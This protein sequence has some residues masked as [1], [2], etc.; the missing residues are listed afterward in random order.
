MPTNHLMAQVNGS[1]NGVMVRATAGVTMY[2]GAGAGSEQT[3]SAVIAD[4]VDVAR[5]DGTHAA[6]QVPHLGFM[7]TPWTKQLAVLPRAAIITRH[8]LRV[9][10]HSAE[11]IRAVGAWL[12]AQR[13]PVVQMALAAEK[14]RPLGSGP[15][16]LVLTESVAQS[17]VDWAVH[18]L[19]AHPAV[20]GGGDAAGRAAGRLR[21]AQRS[22]FMV[23]I[24]S[25]A[26]PA[27]AGSYSF[28]CKRRINYG[29]AP[30]RTSAAISAAA[31]VPSARR[32]C[33]TPARSVSMRF[34]L[35]FQRPSQRSTASSMPTMARSSLSM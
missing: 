21:N 3:A 26:Y 24:G 34:W 4:L 27:S 8:Y 28:D 23:K 33:T 17:T 32:P 9:P 13:A 6:Q 2:Y 19:A 29:I 7:P 1:M 12:A 25:S 10:V 31:G 35:I 16:V 15:Q 18:A 5:L 22:E 30:P 14:S 20:G 11:Q